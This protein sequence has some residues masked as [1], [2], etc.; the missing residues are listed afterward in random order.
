MGMIS[1]III[2]CCFDTSK[3]QEGMNCVKA[4]E[5]GKQ[6]RLKDEAVD[7]NDYYE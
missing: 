2:F 3:V 7:R 4:C 1:L 6:E 5:E